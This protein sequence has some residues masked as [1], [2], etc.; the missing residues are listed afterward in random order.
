MKKK[1]LI[2]IFENGI[3]P[4]KIYV[5]INPTEDSIKENFL[6]NDNSEIKLED[7]SYTMAF[8]HG[9]VVILKSDGN[10]GV[11]VSIINKKIK[12]DVIAHEAT[13]VA[14]IIWDWIGENEPSEEA[15]AYLVGYAAKCIYNAIKN[16]KL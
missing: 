11:L 15:N 2:H 10:V 5:V 14:N 8:V 4:I 13:H 7:N 16:I 1:S 9:N 12:V 6:N 3:Y